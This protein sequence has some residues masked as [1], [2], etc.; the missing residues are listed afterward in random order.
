MTRLGR[1]LLQS[2]LS[3]L[4][5][6]VPES[7]LMSPGFVDREL[8]VRAELGDQ[9]AA[10][11][12][13]MRQRQGSTPL[14][15]SGRF[16]PGYRGYNATVFQPMRR[17]V[18]RVEW[19]CGVR[20]NLLQLTRGQLLDA[21]SCSH[22][23]VEPRGSASLR[24][25]DGGSYFELQLP[26]VDNVFSMEKHTFAAL[27]S[28]MQQA[29]LSTTLGQTEERWLVDRFPRAFPADSAVS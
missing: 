14:V 9:S 18:G 3:A 10:L 8:F 22:A 26:Q 5:E 16:G 6:V 19:A 15:S 29:L 4:I 27:L 28:A 25:C 2:P 24:S 13:F 1:S 11:L 23:D 21:V 17:G 20:T 12:L 7:V